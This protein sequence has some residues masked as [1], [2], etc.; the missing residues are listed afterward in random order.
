MSKLNL[1]SL[2]FKVGSKPGS[3][4]LDIGIT[5]VTVIVGPNNSGKSLAL[6]EIEEYCSGAN[7]VLKVFDEIEIIYPDTFE[8]FEAMMKI[9]QTE[10]PENQIAQPEHFWIARP[11]IR[12]GEN[13][14]HQQVHEPSLVS[15]FGDK[16]RFRNP[17]LS[18]FVKLFTLRLDGRTRFD[19]VDPKETGPLE[20]YP[21][22]HLWALFADDDA[23]GKVRQ[24]TE[25][26]FGKYF[27][28]DPTGMRSFRVRI[29]D[30]EPDS[31][32]EQGLGAESRRF[33]SKSPLVSDLG[34]GLRT[35]IG[36]V[37]AAMSLPHKIL[38]VDEPEAFLHPTLARRVGK[39]LTSTV[40]ERDASMIVATHSSDFLM[41]CIQSY[42]NV[43]LVRLTYIDGV[44]TARSVEPL[45][46]TQMMQDPLL[47]S[48]NVLR[49][50]FHR[51][52][53]VTEAD[54]DRA[55]YEEVNVRLLDIGRGAEDV[56]F[57]NAHSWQQI[58]RI[59]APLRK[60]GIPAVAVMDFDVICGDE[61]RCVWPL[62][63]CEEVRLN[64]LKETRNRIKIKADQIDRQQ[65]KKLGIKA[66]QATDQDEVIWFLNELKLFGVFIVPCGELE[67]WLPGLNVERSNNKPKWLND[68]FLTL[69]SDPEEQDYVKPEDDDIWL[70][71]DEIEVWINNPNREGVPD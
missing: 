13:A 43:R 16:V 59:I 52:V 44:S 47:R 27:T 9:H 57:M 22:N 24:F 38:L 28:I 31:D 10:P 58:P 42:S 51:G 54:S 32:I 19:L 6:R 66:F 71:I 61:F 1:S 21:K 50:L 37:S 3:D 68:I 23:R 64:G 40:R 39:F 14:L 60:L 36:L 33:H 12:T 62:L 49:A 7:P 5:N 30:D 63:H 46:I 25:E 56:L 67:C 11:V 53:V 55:V 45:V 35:S 29:S 8:E 15:W 17:I 2:K 20:G 41:G 65:I 18:N 34:D 4:P 48:T 69:G 70:F 26:A